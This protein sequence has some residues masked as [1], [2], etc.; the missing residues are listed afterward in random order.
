MTIEERIKQCMQ[1]INNL[2][3]QIESIDKQ[4]V[5]AQQRRQALA[6]SYMQADGALGV[7]NEIKA[8]DEKDKTQALN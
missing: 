3:S 7:L 6:N 5:M 2:Q 1:N 4:I 8:C